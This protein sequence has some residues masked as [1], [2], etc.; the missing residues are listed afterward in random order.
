MKVTEEVLQGIEKDA[1]TYRLMLDRL[2]S[3]SFLDD[4][5]CLIENRNKVESIR[6]KI[7]EAYGETLIN[8]SQYPDNC[9][10]YIKKVSLMVSETSTRLLYYLSYKMNKLYGQGQAHMLNK[11][12]SQKI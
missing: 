12:M 11:L 3:D 8:S 6:S 1:E 10:T 5:D 7:T 9:K 4:M 2:Q